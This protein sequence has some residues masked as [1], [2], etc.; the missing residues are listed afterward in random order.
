MFTDSAKGRKTLRSESPVYQDPSSGVWVVST[1]D[2]VREARSQQTRT[3]AKRPKGPS[4]RKQEAVERLLGIVRSLEADYDPLWGSMVKQA[5]KRRKPGFN[6]RY[7]GF[8]SFSELLEQMEEL[9]RQFRCSIVAIQEVRAKDD[10]VLPQ[11]VAAI[12]HQDRLVEWDRRPC[13]AGVLRLAGDRVEERTGARR[14][15]VLA[16]LEVEAHGLP[17]GG[18]VGVDRDAHRPHP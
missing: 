18:G 11:L 3:R 2:L 12:L 1:Y 6:E 16:Q 5:L 17:G 7:H 9:Y 8:R 15:G 14:L 10:N 4:Q 13:A